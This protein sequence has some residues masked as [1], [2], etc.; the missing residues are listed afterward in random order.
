MAK[1]D[2]PKIRLNY[3]PGKD[4]KDDLELAYNRF[5]D[6]KDARSS[7]ETD[8]D[9]WEKQ[10]EAFVSEKDTED[11]QS[12]YFVP[13]TTA[14][15]ES[16]LAEMIDKSPQPLILPREEAD[17]ASATI[18]KNI[19]EY[20]W[21]IG[22]GDI[23]LYKILKDALTFGTGLGQ[24]YYLSLPKKVKMLV[25][26]DK[27]TKKEVY[28]E[29]EILEFD[30][31]YLEAVKLQDLYV[32]DK[33]RYFGVGPY[34][35]RDAIRRYVMG[36]DD[37]RSF[38]TGPIWNH[39]D[40]AK[41]VKAG[42][43]TNYYEYYKPPEAVGEDEVEVLWYWNKPLDKLVIVAN[44]VVV[45]STPNPYSHKQLPFARCVDIM[46][47]HRFYGKGEAE[48][49]KSI[50]DELNRLRR[51]RHD[52]L[53]LSIDQMFLVS[54][55]ELL[56]EADLIARPHG[57]IEVDDINS[58]KPLTYPD[59]PSSSYLEEDRIKEDAIRVTGND[60]RQQSV[61]AAGTATEAAILKEATLKRIRLKL[62]LLERDFLTQVGRLRVANIQQYYSLPKV[63]RIVGDKETVEYQ[64]KV[65]A[66]KE[67]GTY[68]E[69]EGQP[70][71]VT[72]RK[73]RLQDKKLEYDQTT[74]KVNEIPSRGYF[75]FNVLPTYVS[76]Q[77]DVK[78]GAGSTLPISKPLMQSKVMEMIDRIL[79]LSDAAN[80]NSPYSFVKAMDKYI[81]VN[82]YNPDDFKNEA[83][84]N[85]PAQPGSQ[86]H[87]QQ[88][89]LANQENEMM[90]NGQDIQPT[91]YAE[92][93]HTEIHLAFMMSENFKQ[94]PPNDPR[95]QIFTK[96][97]MGENMAQQ[98]RPQGQ[99]QGGQPAMGGMPQMPRAGGGMKMS[100]VIPGKMMGGENTA[101]A[102]FAFPQ[103]RGPM[104]K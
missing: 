73:I 51:M 71:E 25:R 63:R 21:D 13:L 87:E 42:G 74:G 64:Q 40:N 1:K 89:E 62:R 5:E 68:K 10:Y 37:F 8:W 34:A 82:D 98:Q 53:H 100:E 101:K 27:K 46:R 50:N 90:L 23:E 102:P 93:G 67:A 28:E 9:K 4:E 60:D 61:Q 32:D 24:E 49:L 95:V 99:P 43:D 16:Q 86:P 12:D 31:C 88:I 6:M 18:V 57:K 77:L 78:I 69:V 29:Q 91:P 84:L 30:D 11:W 39:L 103:G 70:Y 92:V 55:R 85:P 75:F 94:I 104:G 96:H 81:E 65:A 17:Q 45:R 38:F 56:N 66:T 47:P 36:M 59:T 19:F 3:K 54:G 2:E 14:S 80:P 48:L 97:V 83:A 35:C 41:Y 79:P 76:G 22:D 72:P 52:R 7:T 20:T 44:D 26:Y 33:G 58:I 15:I